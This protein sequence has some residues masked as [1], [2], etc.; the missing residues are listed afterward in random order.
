MQAPTPPGGAMIRTGWIRRFGARP[1]GITSVGIFADT[2]QKTGQHNDFTVFI[3]AG[4]DGQ[5]VYIL[6]LMRDR[7]EAPDLIQAAKA[8]YGRHRPNRLTNPVRFAGFF[9]EDKVCLLYTS[10]SVMIRRFPT[11]RYWKG[12]PRQKSLAGKRTDRRDTIKQ[13][14]HLFKKGNDGNKQ[15]RLSHK[16]ANHP[17]ENIMLL[18]GKSHVK[19]M[20]ARQLLCFNH[21]LNGSLLGLCQRI[22]LLGRHPGSLKSLAICLLYTSRC[23]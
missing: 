2:A 7:L 11:V 17:L 13:G 5:N 18:H 10:V 16:Q 21:F 8:F 19:I 3:L 4:T 6:D 23:V 15:C 14:I 12:L 1:E 22:G 9:V 20:L